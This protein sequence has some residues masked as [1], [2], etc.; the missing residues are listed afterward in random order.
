MP[1]DLFVSYASEDK[2][3][4]AEP[5][6]SALSAKGFTVWYDDFVLKVGDSLTGEINRGLAQSNYGVVVFSRTFFAKH[7][8]QAEL[9]ALAQRE[10][11]GRP[12]LLPVWYDVGR[13]DMLALAPLWVDRL[14]ARWEQGID[15]VVGRLC[16]AMGRTD[17]ARSAGR[18][19]LLTLA[20][21]P[22]FSELPPMSEAE[23][24]ANCGLVPFGSKAGSESGYFAFG[25]PWFESRSLSV[26]LNQAVADYGYPSM[27]RRA[28]L[29]SEDDRIRCWF[30]FQARLIEKAGGTAELIE[31]SDDAVELPF[32]HRVRTARFVGTSQCEY[33]VVTVVVGSRLLLLRLRADQLRYDW[34]RTNWITD[35]A[36]S[37][38]A[39]DAGTR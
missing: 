26:K 37:K 30:D 38:L 24:N 15:V 2:Q 8:P 32:G 21:L 39:T 5:L 23:D 19:V 29:T 22:G 10:V 3:A 36:A 1:W 25:T 33:R 18:A 11:A 35:L 12:V 17:L 7:W 14:A 27:A 28:L 34:S 16:E 9:A 4:V 31:E 13:D 6:A 20:E